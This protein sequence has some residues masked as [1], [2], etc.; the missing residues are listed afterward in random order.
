MAHPRHGKNKNGSRIRR[1]AKTQ[2]EVDVKDIV[3]I[4]EFRAKYLPGDERQRAARHMT[5]Q[6]IGEDLARTSLTA[7][8]HALSE[9][10]GSRA[11][12]RK[13]AAI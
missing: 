1:P 13:S 2:V 6:E 9:R 4:E 8:K 5:P 11:A 10:S 3:S 12:H 7:A